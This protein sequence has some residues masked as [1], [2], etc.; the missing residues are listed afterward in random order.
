MIQPVFPRFCQL[1]PPT[2]SLSRYFLFLF[3]PQW[4]KWFPYLVPYTEYRCKEGWESSI[5]VTLFQETCVSLA[6]QLVLHACLTLVLSFSERWRNSVSLRVKLDP[7]LSS[8]LFSLPVGMEF[9]LRIH[10]HQNLFRLAL[11]IEKLKFFKHLEWEN[12]AFLISGKDKWWPLLTNG[13]TTNQ[14][15]LTAI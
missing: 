11:W 4:L 6:T 12:D 9:E 2:H 5:L 7:S 13:Q 15:C 14:V 10:G 8:S 3:F 1:C